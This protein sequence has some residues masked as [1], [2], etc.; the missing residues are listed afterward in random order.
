[1]SKTETTVKEGARAVERGNAGAS[2]GRTVAK[3]A[4]CV[5]VVASLCVI[6]VFVNTAIG[7]VPVLT[8]LSLIVLCRVYL[9]VLRRFVLFDDVR[10]AVAC[11]RGEVLRFP[12][13]V[14]NRS[15]LP[16]PRIEVVFYI[17]DIFGE[18]GRVERTVLT[19][20]PRSQKV[21][22]L[23]VRFD[24]I[25]TVDVGIRQVT[26]YDPLGVFSAVERNFALSSVSIIPRQMEVGDI[27]L[28][29]E[30][31]KESSKNLRTFINDGMDYLGTREYRWGD[32]MKSIHWK[33]SS[34]AVDG[35]YTRLYETPTTPGLALFL[36]FDSSLEDSEELMC[37]YDLLVE[38]ALAIEA[39]AAGAGFETEMLFV[40]IN[41]SFV[42]LRGPLEGQSEELMRR[43]PRI[44]SGGSAEVIELISAES[45]SLRC[46]NNLVVCT[47]NICREVVDACAGLSSPSRFPFLMGVVSAD[48]GDARKEAT[49]L[50]RASHIPYSLISTSGM[51][52]KGVD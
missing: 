15:I 39:H 3:A 9:S 6:P 22:N 20:P 33:L 8:A 43:I 34:K 21:F 41:G 31:L 44:R 13:A 1:M 4:T 51:D 32:P 18:G 40:D 36:D 14:R 48:G 19:L 16:A 50:L 26:V 10:A 49:R 28:S 35:Y 29:E 23:G 38:S 37:A 5:A 46:Q 45:A 52:A 12:L 27:E 47:S 24:H 11:T 7:Y 30:S 2:R 42:R 17:S 25:G